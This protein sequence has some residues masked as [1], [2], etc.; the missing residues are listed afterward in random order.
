MRIVAYVIDECR[1]ICPDCIEI[2]EINNATAVFEFSET[3][4]R[5]SCERCLEPL[6]EICLHWCSECQQ[7][8]CN[9][10]ECVCE[11][12]YYEPENAIK[13]SQVLEW[14]NAEYEKMIQETPSEK[15]DRVLKE[16]DNAIEKKI[17][18]KY[19]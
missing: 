19:D 4:I 8:D 12:N 2:D 7:Y 5:S 6:D 9:I 3:D 16:C 14:A 15:I 1:L 18:R 13:I 17:A 11:G 10:H